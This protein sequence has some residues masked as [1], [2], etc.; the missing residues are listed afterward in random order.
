MLLCLCAVGLKDG[1]IYFNQAFACWDKTDRP[2]PIMFADERQVTFLLRWLREDVLG[3]A[4]RFLEHQRL[5]GRVAILQSFFFGIP[6][7][8]LSLATVLFLPVG[9]LT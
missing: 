8:T 9:A 2:W 3:V 5:H 6:A 1:A 4:F 7:L